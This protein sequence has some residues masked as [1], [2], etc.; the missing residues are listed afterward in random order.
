MEN[1]TKKIGVIA[2]SFLSGLLAIGCVRQGPDTGSS[3]APSGSTARPKRPIDAA[4]GHWKNGETDLYVSKGEKGLSCTWVF[5]N[6]LIEEHEM[7]N[8]GENLREGTLTLVRWF[9]ADQRSDGKP[10]GVGTFSDGRE[11]IREWRFDADRNSFTV[12]YL[13]FT[14]GMTQDETLRYTDSAQKP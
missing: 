11:I 14:D 4:L 13:H 2:A 6:G 1:R 12:W 3:N 8:K 9:R 5:P 7:V 10:A